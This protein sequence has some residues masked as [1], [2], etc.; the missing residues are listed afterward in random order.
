MAACPFL[1]GVWTFRC[2][3]RTSFIIPT[4][5]E[6]TRYCLSKHPERCPHYPEVRTTKAKDQPAARAVRNARVL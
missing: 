2:L 5:T 3:A 6:E 1:T 4:I